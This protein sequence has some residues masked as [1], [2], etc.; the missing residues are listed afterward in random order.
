M[1]AAHILSMAG[2]STFAA[3]L[4]ELRTLWRLTNAEAGVVSGMFFVGYA[5]S[6]SYWTALTDRIDARRVYAIGSLLAAA[7]SAG[8]GLFAQGFAS[9]VAFQVLLG[10]GVAATYMPG[11]RLL[12]DRAAGPAQSRYIAFYTSFFGIGTALSLAAAGA[13]SAAAGWQ[14]AFIA[15]GAGPLAAGALVVAGIDARAPAARAAQRFSLGALFPLAAWR[16]LLAN[17]PVAGFALGYAMHCLELFGSRSWMVAFLAFVAGLHAGGA[18]F[19]WNLAV[20]AAIVNVCA[21]PASI[22]G[23]EIAIRIGRRRWIAF[24]MFGSG[25]GG[26][27]LAAS[28]P[29]HWTAVL[30]ILLVYSMLV[31]AE[32]ATL[33]AGMVAAAPEEMRGTA[34]GLYS[35]LGFAGGMI[36]P[37]VFG[38]ALDAAGGAVRHGAWLAAYAS[39]GAGAL[40]SSLVAWR[41][42]A[43]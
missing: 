40:V 29:W 17:R 14:W 25:A 36:G 11:L 21:V 16:K 37:M 3:L 33:T 43:G 19:P 20:I 5:G 2:F 6:V 9:A 35:L 4:P 39:I 13:L 32:S 31:M 8:F 7:G 10:A 12:S 30:A 15:A 23:N 24:A 41:R 28:A 18:T 34:M 26:L 27:A 1:L 38:A 22:L 42:A